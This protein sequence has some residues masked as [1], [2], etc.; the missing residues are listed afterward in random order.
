MEHQNFDLI[1]I[2][3]PKTM[4]QYC[5]MLHNMEQL[6]TLKESLKETIEEA[7]FP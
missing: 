4:L 3:V 6:N 5:K 2:E 1:E 7:P